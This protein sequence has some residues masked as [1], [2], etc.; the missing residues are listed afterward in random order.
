MVR[1][2]LVMVS[3]AST[4]LTCHP[5]PDKEKKFM[6]KDYCVCCFF[7]LW[8]YHILLSFPCKIKREEEEGFDT[9]GGGGGSGPHLFD[10]S[11]TL[12]Q[13]SYD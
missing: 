8:F 11:A 12:L 9:G 13:L 6:I 4:L 5:V 10:T 2:F 3:E 1:T 7:L